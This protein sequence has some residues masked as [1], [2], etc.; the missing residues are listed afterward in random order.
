MCSRG[1]YSTSHGQ[2]HDLEQL[3]LSLHESSQPR[4]RLGFPYCVSNYARS[5]EISM[6]VVRWPEFA[7]FAI[8]LHLVLRQSARPDWREAVDVPYSLSLL[9][10]L[11][12]ISLRLELGR[13]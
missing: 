9:C 5:A 2:Q 13:S 6:K 4:R 3:G 11:V 1:K 7:S 8:A 12:M 10:T